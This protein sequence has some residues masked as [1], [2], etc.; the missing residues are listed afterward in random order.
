MLE[1][2]VPSSAIPNTISSG[3]SFL[4]GSHCLQPAYLTVP[5]RIYIHKDGSSKDAPS[6]S[7]PSIGGR[8]SVPFPIARAQL[9][10]GVLNGR[11]RCLGTV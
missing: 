9:A 11:V 5:I 8:Y 4:F 7:N 1:R 3:V 10:A 6:T 2:W